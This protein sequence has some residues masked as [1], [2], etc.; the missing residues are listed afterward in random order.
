MKEMSWCFSKH[1]YVSCSIEGFKVG[2][3]WEMGNK[4]KITIRQGSKYSETPYEYTKE[5]VVDA[6]Y[7][8]YRK[9]YEMNYV[10]EE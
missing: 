10:K 9:L 3:Y 4:Y 1:I 7:D 2:Q 8:T 6:I 5:N